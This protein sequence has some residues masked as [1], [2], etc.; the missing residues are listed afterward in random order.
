MDKDQTIWQEWARKLHAWGVQGWAASLLEAA[1][2]LTL[3][4]AQLIYL[5]QPVLRTVFRD[6]GLQELAAL[7]EEPER[8][9][10]FAA[11]LREGPAA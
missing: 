8:A 10:E 3:L 1:G 11:Y 5:G 7:L 6:P 2:P 9:R 4:G